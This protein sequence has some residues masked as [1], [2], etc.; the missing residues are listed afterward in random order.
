MEN[1]KAW[2]ETEN[3]YLKGF[4]GKL[5][6]YATFKRVNLNPKFVTNTDI[7]SDIKMSEKILVAISLIAGMTTIV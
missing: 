1:G 3:G 5:E 7:N 4:Y 6:N 2:Q